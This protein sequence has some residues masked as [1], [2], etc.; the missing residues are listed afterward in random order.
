MKNV[1][2]IALVMLISGSLFAQASDGTVEFQKKQQPAAVLVLPYTPDMVN[3]ALNDFL[4]KKGRSKGS[5]MK[6]FTTYRNTQALNGDSANAD[7]YFKVERKSRQ[8]KQTTVV[9]LLL[10]PFAG[11]TADSAMHYLSMEEAKSYLNELVPTI[12]GYNLEQQIRDMNEVI[13]QSEAQYKNMMKDGADLE[14]KRSDIDA[15]IQSGKQQQ[16]VQT[17]D[18]DSKK[19]KLAELVS[20]RKSS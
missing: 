9:S 11:N 16:M 17:A 18:I 8:E 3:A 4:S 14:Q 2:M 7:L 10:T 15:R 20:R 12:E 5:D 6:G 1:F 13:S 19:K